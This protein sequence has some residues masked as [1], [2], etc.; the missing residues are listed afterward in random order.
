MRKFITL[1]LLALAD[2]T[3]AAPRVEAKGS[4]ASASPTEFLAARSLAIPG[5]VELSWHPV[6]GVTEYTI[7]ASRETADNWQT[8]GTTTGVSF[9]V[10]E[11]PEGTKYYFRIASNG[12]SDRGRW[13]G[14]VIQYSSQT[15]DFRPAL[16]LPA[17]F[18]VSAQS[19]VAKVAVPSRKGELALAWN[20]VSGAK[21]YVVQICEAEQC[22]VSRGEAGTNSRFSQDEH[23]R[24]LTAV[25]GTE[26]VVT[27]LLSGKLYMFRIVGID[28]KGHPG[29][30]S[31]VR[32][33]RAP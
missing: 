23:F 22:G 12:G 28:D 21:S 1:L 7:S 10:N 17:N 13:S 16:L 20:A 27:G 19:M 32:G 8:L 2:V 15:K 3:L 6:K 11:L 5:T 14:A 29:S 25:P 33:N 4:T 26:H 31:Q 24:D 18:R 9:Q 30:F